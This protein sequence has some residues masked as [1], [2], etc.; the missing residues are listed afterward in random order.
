MAGRYRTDI[1]DLVQ[2]A[3]DL[4]RRI[5]VL[6][7]VSKIGS[8]SIDTGHLIVKDGKI[9]VEDPDGNEV[10]AFFLDPSDLIEAGVPKIRIYPA[11]SDPNNRITMVASDRLFDGYNQTYV[12]YT[13][14]GIND[15]ITDP[16]TYLVAFESG[17]SIGVFGPSEAYFQSRNESLFGLDA[18]LR[19]V[20]RWL[21]DTQISS[22][23][24]L[25]T[26]TKC[27]C[28]CQFGHNNLSI[29]FCNNGGSGYWVIEQCWCTQLV[30]HGTKRVKFYRRLDRD[31]RQRNKHVEYKNLG[32]TVLTFQVLSAVLKD[33]FIHVVKEITD[34]EGNVSLNL[35]MFRNDTWSGVPPN[36]V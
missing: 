25:Y 14:N 34:D 27:K 19:I 7:R 6:E 21:N 17:C 33:N 26:G 1:R 2:V 20:G 18:N 30:S 4:E 35:H 29:G 15:D 28:W 13:V 31:A 5:S 16:Y 12:Q 3:I 22:T 36:S 11:G 23:D 9:S 24:A 10:I 8:T 32:V